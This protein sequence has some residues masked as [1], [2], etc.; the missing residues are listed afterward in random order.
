MMIA[1]GFASRSIGARSWKGRTRCFAANASARWALTS[2]AAT[3]SA[4]L[5]AASAYG[6]LGLLSAG[7]VMA[8]GALSDRF[9]YRQTVSVSFA[10]VAERAS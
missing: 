7:S 6:F 2:Q 3:N 5:S 10:W 1:S 4:S 8:S 9:G